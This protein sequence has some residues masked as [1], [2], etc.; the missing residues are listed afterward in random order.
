[1]ASIMD[2]KAV[3]FALEMIK[4]SKNWKKTHDFEIANQIIRSGTSIGANIR[5]AQAAQSKKDFVHKLSISLK[6]ARETRFWLELL[7]KSEMMDQPEYKV[8]DGKA[9]ELKRM[10]TSSIKTTKE[11]YNLKQY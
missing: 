8:L 7:V 1:M 11:K 6:E 3:L 10:L 5:E 2:D 9:L 4:L